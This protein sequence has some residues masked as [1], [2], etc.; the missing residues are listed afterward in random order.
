[1]LYSEGWNATAAADV[2]LLRRREG[3]VYD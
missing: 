2:I 1:M 3:I